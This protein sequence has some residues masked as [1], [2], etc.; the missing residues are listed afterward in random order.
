[1]KVESHLKHSEEFQKDR[2]HSEVFDK[3]ENGLVLIKD[4]T[5]SEVFDKLENGLVLIMQSVK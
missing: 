1:M 2:T 4:R 3:L 5:H